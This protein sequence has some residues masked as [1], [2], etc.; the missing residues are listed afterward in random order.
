VF[1]LIEQVA[2]RAGRGLLPGRVIV[3]TYNPDHP[4]ITFAKKHDVQGFARHE[5]AQRKMLDLPPYTRLV[6]FEFADESNDKARRE[7][8][9]LARELRRRV[10]KETDVI[11]PTSCYFTRKNRRYRWQVLVRTRSPSVLL[12]GLEIPRYCVVDVDPINIL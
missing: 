8:E 6:K 9:M 7:C 3:Q 2:G 4:A 11:G 10:P 5:L 1:N 12:D